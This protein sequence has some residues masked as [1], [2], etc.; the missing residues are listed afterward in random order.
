MTVQLECINH[1]LQF[2]KNISHYAGIMLNAFSPLLCPKLY[3]HNRLVS[4]SDS[5]KQN[6]IYRDYFPTHFNKGSQSCIRFV[7]MFI[8]IQKYVHNYCAKVSLRVI[9]IIRSTTL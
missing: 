1:L 3:W 9:V 5:A 8:S 6:P 2:S 7:V 4:T